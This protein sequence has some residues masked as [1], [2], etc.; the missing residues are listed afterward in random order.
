MKNF[1]LTKKIQVDVE[2]KALYDKNYI[3]GEDILENDS[4]FVE[5]MVTYEEA[6]Q[7]DPIWN[8]AANTRKA[9]RQISDWVDGTTFN[10]A[11]D[12]VLN[13]S[14]N[15]IVELREGTEDGTLLATS[16]ILNTA[17]T[18]S[19][20][21]FTATRD[22][23][24]TMPP[25]WTVVWYVFKQAGDTINASN[26]YRIYFANKDTTTRWNIKRYSWVSRSPFIFSWSTISDAHSVNFNTFNFETKQKWVRLVANK[27]II[28]KTVTKYNGCSAT[29]ALLKTDWWAVI[30]TSTFIWTVATFT[31]TIEFAIWVWFRIELDNNWSSYYTKYVSSPWFPIAD[32]NINWSTWSALWAND[33]TLWSIIS[34]ETQEYQLYN[35]IAW[36]VYLTSA[37]IQPQ[38]LSKSSALY[39]YKIPTDYTRLALANYS[40]GQEVTATKFWQHDYDWLVA[41]TV[42]YQSDTPWLIS[43]AAGTNSYV[44]GE[45]I[46]NGILNVWD[47]KLDIWPWTTYTLAS[48]NTERIAGY[49]LILWKSATIQSR[50]TYTVSFEWRNQ[51]WYTSA[52][53]IRVNWN[54]VHS[55]SIYW[56]IYTIREW[57][58]DCESWDI[59]EIYFRS[60]TYSY[61]AYIRNTTIKYDYVS[62][63]NKPFALI[64]PTVD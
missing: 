3:A 31:N 18:T 51:S 62:R 9:V 27:N 32:T 42:Y 45:T 15:L 56:N 17:I 59:I 43:A 64:W 40:T 34:I 60:E 53:Q 61:N 36:F 11:V 49:D 37:S 28:V 58:V 41:N 63:Q 47:N 48:L 7:A 30:Q 33:P 2:P 4:L 10:F 29:R 52:Y 19:K 35:D 1:H 20:T 55:L 8:I 23:T 38:L 39:S 14:V 54:I 16:T 13:P 25:K 50:W 26:Y 5:G 57:N 6:T 21:N 46:D 24:F 22:V 44:I 12:K